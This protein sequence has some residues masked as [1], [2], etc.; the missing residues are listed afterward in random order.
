MHAEMSALRFAQPGDVLYVMRWTKDGEATMS[1][2]CPK[3]QKVIAEANLKKV[4]YTNWEGE[5]E[6]Y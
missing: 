2:P 4:F 1:K 3:C 6:R 5:F